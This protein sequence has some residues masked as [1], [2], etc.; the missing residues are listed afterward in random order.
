MGLGDFINDV[1]GS[2]NEERAEEH[3]VDDNAYEYGGQA[4]GADAAA[5][6]YA[7]YGQNAQQR[8]GVYTDYGKANGWEQ[9]GQN[10]R[11]RQSQVADTMLARAM[12]QTP[13][14]AQM[15]ADRQMQQAAAE[16]A[17][18]AAGARGPGAM[19]LA[20]QNA[21][22]NVA[23]A[24]ANISGQAQ[25]NAAGER[26]QAEQAAMGAYGGMRGQ[27]AQSQQMAANQAQFQSQMN[28]AQRARNDQYQ[29]GMTQA[30]MGVRNSQLSAQQNKQAQQS[31]NAQ[32]AQTINAGVAGQNAASAQSMGMGV[33]GMGAS[34]AGGVA[35]AVASDSRAKEGIEPLTPSGVVLARSTWG[36]KQDDAPTSF[37]DIS[38]SQQSLSPSE[39]S[40][41]AGRT[42]DASRRAEAYESPYQRDVREVGALRKVNPDLVNDDDI[43]RERVGRAMSRGESTPAKG[44]APKDAP[45]VDAAKGEA[46]KG[47][48]AG[49]L[50]SAFGDVGKGFTKLA[51]SFDNGYHGPT[52][53]GGGPQLLAVQT[54]ALMT[55]YPSDVRTKIMGGLGGAPDTGGTGVDIGNSPGITQSMIKEASTGTAGNVGIRGMVGGGGIVGGSMPMLNGPGGDGGGKMYSDMGTKRPSGG[56]MLNFS[57]A[58]ASEVM[59]LAEREGEEL[60][61]S[62][63]GRAFTRS[64]A[65]DDGRP[66]LAGPTPRFS[67]SEAVPDK[68]KA[69]AKP[70]PAKRSTREMTPEEMMAWANAQQAQQTSDHEARMAAGPMVSDERTK[71]VGGPDPMQSANRAQ[72]SAIYEY[73]PEFKP[74]EQTPGEKNVGPMAQT[75]AKDPMAATAVRKDPSGIL[76]LDRDKLSKLHSAGISSLQDQVDQLKAVLASR[77]GK[78]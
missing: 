19:A 77:M 75:M 66:S 44:E 57:L 73:K 63:D 28:D 5:N 7:S 14:I 37:E 52:S 74:P 56:P 36:A 23:N 12:G 2:E 43:R 65:E 26:M 46:G 54:P 1:F 38:R 69:K 8:Q 24:Q 68:P 67:V 60:H 41:L 25:V 10:V 42:Q 27:D 64:A 55:G 21:A 11:G 48:V 72:A 3:K 62:A 15:Q 40:S 17:S 58:D 31:G 70:A 34:V 47:G 35:G 16:Q 9:E 45:K 78:R 59:P 30:E 51:G 13:S 22:S 20:Q 33:L 61:Q 76:T 50:G 53:T 18:A 49:A 6:K 71:R 32:A 4:G 39:A 29:M